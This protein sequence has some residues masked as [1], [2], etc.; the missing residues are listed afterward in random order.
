MATKKTAKKTKKP[1]A[2][3]APEV[4]PK[5]REIAAVICAALG[6]FSLLSFFTGDGWFLRFFM[7]LMRGLIG[8]GYFLLPFALIGAAIILGFHRGRPV[9]MRVACTMLTTVVF[10]SVWHLIACT[11]EYEWSFRM[12]GELF[13]DGMEKGGAMSGGVISGLLAVLFK[14][15]FSK[16]GAAIVF[17]VVLVFLLLTAFN[18]TISKIIEKIRE[19]PR[20]EY[21][22][23]PER[24]AKKPETAVRSADKPEKRRRRVFDAET[25]EELKATPLDSEPKAGIDLPVDGPIKPIPE[26]KSFFDPNPSVKTPD[27]VIKHGRRAEAAP[28]AVTEPA[29]PAPVPAPAPAPEPVHAAAP[30]QTFEPEAEPAPAF[31]PSP[32]E[33]SAAAAKSAAAKVT[34]DEAAEAELEV[35]ADIEKNLAEPEKPAY[36]FP[37]VGLLTE[38]SPLGTVDGSEETRINAERLS[39]ALRSFGLN[40][41]ISSVTRGPSVTRYEVELEQGVR[42]N[43]L[44]N[45]ADDIALSLGA[46]GVRIAPVPDKISIVGIEVPNKLTN[47]VT[48]REIIDSDKFRQ[49]KSPLSFAIGKDIGDSPVV[50][51]ISKLPHM[52]IAG[53]TGSGKSVCMNSLILS[54]LYKSPPE[55]VRLIMIDPKMIEL[56]IYNGIPHMLIP[57]VTDPKKAA[58]ALQWAVMEMLKRYKQFSEKGVRDLQGYNESVDTSIGEQKLPRIVVLIDELADLMLVAAKDVEE[59]ICRVAQMGRAS[60]IHLVIATQRPSADV[61]TGLMKANIPSRIAFAVDSSLNSRII[62]DQTGAE[63]LVG[64]GDMLYFPLGSGK[65][66]RVQGTFVTDQEREDVINFVK[67]AGDAE[68]SQEIL[69]EIERNAEGKDKGAKTVSDTENTASELDDDADELLDD[70]VMVVLESGQASVSMLQRR[71]KLGYS[72]AAR[73]VDQMEE[74]GIVGPFEGSKPR[75]LLITREE[76]EARKNG[77]AAPQMSIFEAETE[78]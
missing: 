67:R 15:L 75:P 56:G 32:H 12:F 4:Q 8:A 23:E 70:A 42:L 14:S 34:S 52:L 63:K 1:A 13:S 41:E 24:P 55:D 5:R 30:V 71:L 68:Y 33:Q 19:R 28:A 61:I 29:A 10:G 36:E 43:K 39:A 72:R 60:G 16:A 77:E 31:V 50:G 3:A 37:P 27:Q 38:S 26:K 49:A 18:L 48:L 66:M 54:L 73:I 25:A 6:V 78:E 53:T 46:S 64:K 20:R 45:L 57:V 2:K 40:T 22:P 51:D 69:S 58:G 62:L 74:R 76:W 9:R 7:V 65:P 11:T 21:T 44:T 35:A 47:V 59:S 17:I